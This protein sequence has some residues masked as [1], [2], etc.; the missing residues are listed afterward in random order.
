LNAL[1]VVRLDLRA[2]E[3]EM[4]FAVGQRTGWWQRIMRR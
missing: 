2:L 4:G 1:D 3:G